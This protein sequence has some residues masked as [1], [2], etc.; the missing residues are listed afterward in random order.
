VPVV[1]QEEVQ[2]ILARVRER[3]GVAAPAPL[4]VET[5]KGLPL[6]DAIW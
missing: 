6:P 1:R 4:P 3:M 2:A 5:F